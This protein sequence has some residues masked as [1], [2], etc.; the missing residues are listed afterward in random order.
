MPS[1]VAIDLDGSRLPAAWTSGGIYGTQ[2]DILFSPRGEVIGSAAAA[3]VMNFIVADVQ[4]ITAAVQEQIA[5]VPVAM[6]KFRYA[7][8]R[9]PALRVEDPSN[10]AADPELPVKINDRLVTLFA[11]TGQVTT[12]QVNHFDGTLSPYEFG[13]AGK[14]AP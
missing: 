1:G 4:N 6:R 13:L 14:D 9:S 12:S 11:R 5:G 3:G 2:L 10:P 8:Q 7:D